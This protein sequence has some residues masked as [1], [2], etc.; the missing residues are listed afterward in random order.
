MTPDKT[1]SASAIGMKPG[2]DAINR[3]GRDKGQAGL[4]KACGDV[5]QSS[6]DKDEVVVAVSKVSVLPDRLDLVVCV[7]DDSCKYV[8]PRLIDACKREFPE[9][10]FHACK[11]EKG[12]LFGDV[13]EQA[14]IPHLLEHLVITLQVRHDQQT[15]LGNFSYYG[16][17]QWLSSG[18][19]ACSDDNPCCAKV[20]VRF[21]NDVVALSC[22][23]AAVAFVNEWF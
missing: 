15:G 11:N 3:A 6:R 4:S 1:T 21:R 5:S 8:T 9:L 12:P 19:I 10:A 22:L 18:R 7:K 14:S 16:T 17:T 2:H 20:S 13:M 23:K